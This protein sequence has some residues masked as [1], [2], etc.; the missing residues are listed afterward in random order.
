M[1][2]PPAPY[3]AQVNSRKN[4]QA[5]PRDVRGM[6]GEH[7]NTTALTTSGGTF[8]REELWDQESS[9]EEGDC[10]TTADDDEQIA[11]RQAARQA[12]EALVAKAYAD[13][14]NVHQVIA[15]KELAEVCEEQPKQ[16]RCFLLLQQESASAL[17]PQAQQS[18]P[19]T[20]LAA[21]EGCRRCHGFEP[22]TK[23]SKC[24]ECGCDLIHHIAPADEQEQMA[25]SDSEEEEFVQ[26][27][28]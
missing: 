27:I 17:F 28:E 11:R 5:P 19:R 2:A 1:A 18:R 13:E 6:A 20:G 24:V 12:W 8:A 26:T 4:D 10:P 7:G 16:P 23:G 21:C 22:D 15:A 25:C 14:S 9:D 3:C